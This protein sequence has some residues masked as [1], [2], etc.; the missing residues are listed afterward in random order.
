MKTDY[1]AFIVE[2]KKTEPSIIRNMANIFFPDSNNEIFT[3]P[4][5]KNLFLLWKKLEEDNF[6]TDLIELLRE[7]INGMDEKLKGFSRTDFSEIFLFFDF[8]FQQNNLSRANDETAE[9]IVIKMLKGFDNETE[10]GKLYISYPMVE[11]LRDFSSGICGNGDSCK[12]K[13]SE[14]S[15]YKE[16]SSSRSSFQHF[17]EYNG[18]IWNA[19][20]EVFAMRVSCLFDQ[21]EVFSYDD[22]ISIVNPLSIYERQKLNLQK[23]TMYV[24]SAF[25]EFLLDY[26]GESFW[27]KCIRDVN[28]KNENCDYLR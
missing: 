23:D 3:I 28:L 15:G 1:K 20:T 8:D 5:V 21:C 13:I 12:C 16:I 26:F 19:L 27:S 11:A 10:N 9:E 22:Y 18:H 17:S 4:A 7:S 2:G 25:P 14:L 24:L 6:E